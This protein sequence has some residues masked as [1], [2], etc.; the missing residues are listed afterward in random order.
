[1]DDEY[2]YTKEDVEKMLHFLSAY[3][4]KLATPENAVKALVYLRDKTIAIEKA[5]D[6]ELKALLQ[7]LEDF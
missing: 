2:Q 5:S 1:M 6:D 4:P 7:D 3:F